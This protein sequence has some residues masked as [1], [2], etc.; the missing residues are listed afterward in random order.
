MQGSALSRKTGR[1]LQYFS[2]PNQVLAT[3]DSNHTVEDRGTSQMAYQPNPGHHVSCCAG[4]VHRI[5]PNYVVRMWMKH[6]RD[7]LAATLY[8]PSR[9]KTTAGAD[10]QQVE[11]VQTTNYPFEDTIRLKFHSAK[12][13]SF[14]LYL[15]IPQWCKNP[16]IAVNGKLVA[17]LE[18]AHNF[19]ILRRTFQPGDAITL[20]F[21]NEDSSDVLA[22]RRYCRG[23][24][25]TRLCATN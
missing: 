1:G 11:I 21:P 4:N 25:S 5:H 19:A 2:C 24:W 7:G 14:P 10:Q 12:P 18:I 15:R 13:V 8:G 22:A 9:V 23:A 16:E 17:T 6:G 3:L 20:I